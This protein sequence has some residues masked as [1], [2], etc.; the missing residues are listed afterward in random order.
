MTFT[1][2][3]KT[4]YENNMWKVSTEDPTLM[5]KALELGDAFRALHRRLTEQLQKEIP[6]PNRIIVT[7]GVIKATGSEEI[8]IDQFQTGEQLFF[9]I[10]DMRIST[11]FLV[12]FSKD[13][14]LN[15]FQQQDQ[16]VSDNIREIERK[17]KT[18]AFQTGETPEQVLDRAQTELNSQ[19]AGAE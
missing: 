11:S 17:I 16:P 6:T 19:K 3:V 4:V 2:K 12:N 14:D 7:L 15:S 9:N 10:E 5:E 8:D 1:I 13:R 18:I